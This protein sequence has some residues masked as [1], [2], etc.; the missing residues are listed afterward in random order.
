[1]LKRPFRQHP[2][3]A[4]SSRKKSGKEAESSVG[5]SRGS[6]AAVRNAGSL[7]A[8]NWLR[9]TGDRP[10]PRPR[11][12]P[13]GRTRR[14]FDP[15]PLVVPQC[16]APIGRPDRCRLGCQPVHRRRAKDL[17]RA[18]LGRDTPADIAARS[19]NADRRLET[20]NVLLERLRSACHSRCSY[21]LLDR[22][23]RMSSIFLAALSLSSP[24]FSPAFRP[25]SPACSLARM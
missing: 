20:K 6:R 7:S 15:I 16:M 11:H 22:S 13:R 25:N 23:P 10:P 17:M 5:S 18:N 2:S 12:G 9:R 4:S 24:A 21:L 1:M 14:S 3:D 19:E 8:Q